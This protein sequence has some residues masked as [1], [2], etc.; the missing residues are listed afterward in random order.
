MHVRVREHG[1]QQE[2]AEH[3]EREP[4]QDEA[5]VLTEQADPARDESRHDRDPDHD[6]A[7]ERGDHASTGIYELRG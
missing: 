7:G 1:E 2:G 3:E 6:E 5:A 4:A